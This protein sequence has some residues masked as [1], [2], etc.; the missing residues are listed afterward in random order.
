MGSLRAVHPPSLLTFPHVIFDQSTIW[1]HYISWPNY[2]GPLTHILILVHTCSRYMPLSHTCREIHTCLCL[3]HVERYIHASVRYIHA[4]LIQA[5]IYPCI[6]RILASLI[7]ALLH[8]PVLGRQ[9]AVLQALLHDFVTWYL[10]QD[11]FAVTR[12]V[13]MHVFLQ[14][15]HP[16]HRKVQQI[17]S[18][19]GYKAE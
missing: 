15:T 14:C 9:N 11:L 19:M 7:H 16:T 8:E 12:P 2:I 6:Y 13:T 3:I 1:P 10:L 18:R 17:G 5:C 4:S